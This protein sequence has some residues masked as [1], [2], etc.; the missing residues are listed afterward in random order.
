MATKKDQ[1][2]AEA[3]SLKPRDREML[4]EELWSSLDGSTRDRISDEW[5]DEISKRLRAFARGE[6][7]TIPGEQVMREARK[8]VRKKRTA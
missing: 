3:M 6:V 7:Q 1:L 5:A 4:A 8:L 2:F